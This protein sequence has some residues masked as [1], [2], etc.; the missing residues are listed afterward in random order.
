ML[1]VRERN[2]ERSSIRL[3]IKKAKLHQ[4]QLVSFDIVV[5]VSFGWL[6]NVVWLL[7]QRKKCLGK[8]TF[9]CGPPTYLF[10]LF[11][12]RASQ[13]PFFLENYLFIKKNQENHLSRKLFTFVG[14]LHQ[15]SIRFNAIGLAWN[16]N[17]TEE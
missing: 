15:F 17:T 4:A 13:N 16:P 2:T 12:F 8:N 10:K 9:F 7:F 1:S 3:I 6:L 14:R 11:V 5:L